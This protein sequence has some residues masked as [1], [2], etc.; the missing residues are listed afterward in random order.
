MTLT[1]SFAFTI[2]KRL[3]D[4][5]RI[6]EAINNGCRWQHDCQEFLALLLDSLHEQM[7]TAKSSKNCHVPV[8]MST[9]KSSF[10]LI[11]N[12]N[13]K[14]VSSSTATRNS[15]C[16]SDFL[17]PYNCLAPLDS[18]N[19]PNITMAGSLRGI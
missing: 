19:S 16:T 4:N 7:N 2:S 1:K 3:I 13:G 8:T 18:P 17:E 14:N 12:S 10:N 5:S 11:E 6:P 15:N 9:P